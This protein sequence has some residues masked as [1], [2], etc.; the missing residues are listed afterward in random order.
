M[1][2]VVWQECTNKEENSVTLCYSSPHGDGGFPGEVQAS[3]RYT[4]NDSNALIIEYK[5]TVLKEATP[6]SMTN[7]AYFNLA[8]HVSTC[9]LPTFMLII[10]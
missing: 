9:I 1:L 8:G 6:I 5:A 2:Q 4:L 3:V 7:H 10:Y